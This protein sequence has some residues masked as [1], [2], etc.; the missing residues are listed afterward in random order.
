VASPDKFAEYQE[1]R[2]LTYP[3]EFLVSGNQYSLFG[4]LK[5]RMHLFGVRE[6]ARVF[7]LGTDLVG[8]D[9]FSRLLYGSQVSLSASLAAALIS[10]TLGMVLGGVS[11]YYAGRIDIVVMRFSDVFLAMPWLYLLLA[12]RAALPLHMDSRQTYLFLAVLMGLL[13]WARPAR[14]TRGVVL[15]VK[16]TEFVTAARSFGASDLYLFRKHIFPSVRAVLLTQLSIY[17]PQYVLAE[18]TLSFLG[19]GV[20]EPMASWGKMLA[21]L[22]LFVSDPHPW[23]FAPAFALFGVLLAY[24]GLFTYIKGRTL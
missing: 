17:I 13:G 18:V 11:G 5:T 3:L 21:D 22:Q 7:L 4:I 2:T 20:N 9:V 23:L 16:Q 6:P 8:R 24:H 1:D 12:V 19:L 15:T 10:V 14:L